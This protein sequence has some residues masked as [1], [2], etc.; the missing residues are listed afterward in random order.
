[1]HHE[2]Q[3]TLARRIFSLLDAGS[4]DMAD[5]YARNPVS[6]YTSS[7]QLGRE[8]ERLFLDRPLLITASC[9]LKAPGDYLTDDLSG[10]PILVVRD[11][12]GHLNA[13]AN[14][15]RHRG[16]RIAHGSGSGATSFVCPYHGWGYDTQGRLRTVAPRQAFAGLAPDQCNLVR[17]PLVERHGLVWVLPKPDGTTDASTLAPGLDDELASFGF[18]GFAHFETR[19]IRK[20]INW[21]LAI[22]TF[23]EN[24]HFDKLHRDSIDATFLPG[25]A[26]VDRF[27]DNM[28]IVYPRRSILDMRTQPESQ[29][30]LPRHTA[31]AYV[32]FPNAIVIWHGD[33]LHVWRMFPAHGEATGQ[34]VTELAF[35]TPRPATDA[36]SR[37]Y[38]T[39]N[40]DLAVHVVANEDYTVAEDAQRAYEC[41]MLEFITFGRHEPALIYYHERLRQALAAG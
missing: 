4:T 10:V 19:V 9:R 12:A 34:S 36:Q 31:I 11:S 22:D 40:L 23:L 37:N 35:Y 27:G 38:W 29:W 26:L 2:T 3:V 39:R 33:Q 21:K 41:G 14:A 28:R 32:L 18:A 6:A 16:A 1:M 8:N 5:T 15:C 30:D 24:W 17:L 20:R 7:D 13:F 25:I